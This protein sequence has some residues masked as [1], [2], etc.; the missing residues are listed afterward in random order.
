M[1]KS[2]VDNGWASFAHPLG[3][4]R[5]VLLV[6]WDPIGIFGHV[7]AMDEYDD[8]AVE[9]YDL[10]AADAS[11]DDLVSYFHQTQSK[12][13]GVRG[14]SSADLAAIASKIRRAYNTACADQS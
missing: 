10:L 6:D 1:K 12:Q 8:Y 3:F 13:I 14:K 5:L 4:I 2:A 9:V 7:G 11:E